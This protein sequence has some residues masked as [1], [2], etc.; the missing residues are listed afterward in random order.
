M[1][2][3]QE[4]WKPLVKFMAPLGFLFAFAL[5]ASN[6]A[7]RYSTVAFLQFC[8][9]GNVVIMFAMS[10]A[11]GL[12]VFSWK[13]V[14]ILSVVITGCSLCV[15]G[16]VKFV[17]MGFA[18]QIGSQLCECCKNAIGEVVMGG[19]GMK[20]DAL[21][22]VAFQAPFS[23]V[24]LSIA[25]IFL[26]TPG[27]YTAFMGTWHLLLLNAPVAF[28]L[29]VTIA[30]CLKN[31]SALAFV[32]IGVSK[33]IIIVACSSVIFGDSISKLQLSGFAITIL[34]ISLWSHHKLEEQAEAAKMPLV[35]K[36][37]EVADKDAKA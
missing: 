15:H 19:A 32:I 35:N 4:N 29:N 27:V 17:W 36:D 1:G 3:A 21:T 16:E 24:P 2:K 34:G 8:K 9:E 22:F 7:Y 26:Y 37:P 6:E 12:Q 25:S 11:L 14:A 28:I 31:L 13:K 23:L 20:L 5:W 30:L 33:D 18:L 10:C